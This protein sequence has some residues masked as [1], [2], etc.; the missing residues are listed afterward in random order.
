[1]EPKAGKCTDCVSIAAT[2]TARG[3][4]YDPMVDTIPVKPSGYEG[5]ELVCANCEER[6]AMWVR[7]LLAERRWG[8]GREAFL[9]E[10]A[11]EHEQFLAN[12][13]EESRC[14]S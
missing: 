11:A 7:S 10:E 6:R 12:L 8:A 4:K 2:M 14:P 1:M 3:M 5:G 9:A 13:A